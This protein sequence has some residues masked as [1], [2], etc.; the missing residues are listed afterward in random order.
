MK[1]IPAPAYVLALLLTVCFT[2]ATWLQPLSESLKANSAQSQNLLNT[3]MGGAEK[4][5][6]G[7]FFRKA[8]VY[9]HSGYYPS[10]FDQKQAPTNSSHMTA[11]EG[12]QEEE[13]HERQMNFLRPA[14]DWIERFGR[15][16]LITEHTH[17][18][19]GKESES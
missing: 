4:L 8:D 12:S 15:H 3:V 14:N 11:A 10:V 16:F 1:T 19:A 18:Q 9:F 7:L 13:E 5:F 6:A 2:L 17:L